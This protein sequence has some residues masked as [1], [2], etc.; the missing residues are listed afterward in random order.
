VRAK[1]LKS[2]AV[3]R[4]LLAVAF[5]VL[6][7]TAAVAAEPETPGQ[8]TYVRYCGACHGQDGKGNGP[9]A[10]WLTAKPTD[11]TQIAKKAGGEF[12]MIKVIQ[13]IDGTTTVRAHGDSDMPVWGDRFRAEIEASMN[14]QAQ[15]RG[16]IFLIA[17]YL[18]SIQVK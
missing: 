10:N 1:Q 16:K 6:L 4:G 3:A 18:R 8:V 13:A 7:S 2:V 11:L 5:L 14:H 9:V 12:P 15:V 17:D